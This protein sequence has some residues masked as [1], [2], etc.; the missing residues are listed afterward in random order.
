LSAATAAW[1]QRGRGSGSLVAAWQRQRQRSGGS[2]SSAAAAKSKPQ[3]CKKKP[4]KMGVTWT[5]LI[6]VA[7]D[8]KQIVFFGPM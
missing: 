7:C 6:A 5:L 1:Q 8:N 2:S 4:Q 3:F